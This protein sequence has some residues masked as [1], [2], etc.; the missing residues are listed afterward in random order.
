M[1]SPELANQS[2]GRPVLV[3]WE[4]E[5][6]ATSLLIVNMTTCITPFDQWDTFNDVTH[7]II[8]RNRTGVVAEILCVAESTGGECWNMWAQIVNRTFVHSRLTMILDVSC[9]PFVH[10]RLTNIS[11]VRLLSV[12]AQTADRYRGTKKNRKFNKKQENYTLGECKQLSLEKSQ[13]WVRYVGQQTVVR[14]FSAW[15]RGQIY[16]RLLSEHRTSVCCPKLF[17]VYLPSGSRTNR[18]GGRLFIYVY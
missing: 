11:D 1:K 14:C 18:H 2:V 6:S 5:V 7:Q 17:T 13:T 9:F 3:H 10:K 12:C 16:I 8:P 15:L 4:K